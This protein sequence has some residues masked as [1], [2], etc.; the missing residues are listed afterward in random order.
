LITVPRRF[1]RASQGDNVTINLTELAD[2]S[3][4]GRCYPWWWWRRSSGQLRPGRR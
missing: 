3:Q 4:P 2:E 1:R